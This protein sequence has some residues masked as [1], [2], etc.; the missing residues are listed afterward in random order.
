[1][2]L[3]SNLALKGF[4]IKLM[5]LTVSCRGKGAT[6]VSEFSGQEQTLPASITE[7]RMDNIKV[8]D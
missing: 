5:S 2:Q 7:L 6:Q 4:L 1:M 8:C 3:K